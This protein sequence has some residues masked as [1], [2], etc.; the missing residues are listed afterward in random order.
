MTAF[1]KSKTRVTLPGPAGS[2]RLA[3]PKHVIVVGGGLAGCATATIL[4]ERGVKVSVVESEAYLG[5]RVGGWADKHQGNQPF[6]MERGF[7]AFFR[8]YYNVRAWLKRIDPT[9]SCLTPLHDYPIYGKDQ[10]KE[11]FANLPK[12]TPLNLMTLVKR[13]PTIGLLDVLRIPSWPTLEML[14]FHPERTFK[15]YDG[16]TAGEF[17]DSMKFPPEARQMLFDVFAHSFFNPEYE[18][19]AAE[20]IKLFHFYFTGNPEGLV[21]DV[22]NQ[23]FSTGIWDPMRCYLEA[24]GVEFHMDARVEQLAPTKRGWRLKSTGRRKRFDA[25]AVVLA[26]TAK[27][28]KTIVGGSAAITEKAWAAQV[29]SLDQ[30][31]PFAIWRLWLDR[32]TAPGREPFVG[33]AGLGLLDNISLYHLF[34][35][36]SKEYVREHGGSVVEL[37]GYAIPRDLSEE[38]I[39][40]DLWS[41]FVATYPEF[42]GAT[43]QEDRYRYDQ[44]CPA[45][46]AGAYAQRPGVETPYPTLALAGDCVK[47]ELPAAL[48][49]GA[50]TSGFLAAN[51][52]LRAWNVRGEDIHTVPTEGLLS[53]VAPRMNA[54]RPALAP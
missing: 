54:K 39:K 5:G 21:F 18:M 48:M 17:L 14:S 32:E 26:V 49:E 41:H 24:L 43:I 11:S 12:Q 15:E 16:T 40:K 9:L 34:Q 30:T 23:P 8:Q 2:E 4:A 6:T 10:R 52:L 47:L 50:V 3:E 45:F 28:L 46:S 27:A 19:S 1:W 33:T 7:H 29:D 53:R 51:T 31:L 35:S 38:A 20:M 22:L 42:Q 37:H 13:T 44:D 25:D 36:E